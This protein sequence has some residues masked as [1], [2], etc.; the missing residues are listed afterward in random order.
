M[1]WVQT[2]LHSKI[3]TSKQVKSSTNQILTTQTDSDIAAQTGRP[4]VKPFDIP[5]S[6]DELIIRP[7]LATTKRKSALIEDTFL[8][9]KILDSLI[10]MS[11]N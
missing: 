10:M 8:K 2:E 1:S 7:E 5:S 6:G 11:T 9:R 4:A 3:T